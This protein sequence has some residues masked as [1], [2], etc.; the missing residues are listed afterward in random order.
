VYWLA[1][2]SS[3]SAVAP[4]MLKPWPV[5]ALTA[6]VSLNCTISVAD[7][8]EFQSTVPP[9]VLPPPVLPPDPAEADRRKVPVSVSYACAER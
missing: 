9:P 3:T 8:D 4:V 5:R 6:S 2:I 7:I 1:K